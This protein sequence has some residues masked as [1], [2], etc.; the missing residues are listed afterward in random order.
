LSSSG[1]D[2][3]VESYPFPALDQDA[4]IV[5][6][7]PTAAARAAQIIDRAHA[8]AVEISRIAQAQ[9]QDQGFAAGIAQARQQLAPTAEALAAAVRALVEARDEFV[10]TAEHRAVELALAIADKVVGAALEVDPELVRGVVTGALRRATMRD[11]LVLEANPADHELVSVVAEDVAASLGGVTRLEVLAERR[12][13]RGGC[14]VRTGEGE[15]DARV[16]EQL[17]RAGELLLE[18]FRSRGRRA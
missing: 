7:A 11:H 3:L 6:G 16:G 17:D 5:R 9:A 15:I 2:E 14:V 12:V 13:P 8:E 10:E 4:T 1:T 18:M